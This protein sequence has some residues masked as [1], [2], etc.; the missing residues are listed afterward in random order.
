[1]EKNGSA[2]RLMAT[3]QNERL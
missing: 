3:P 1:M 2:A